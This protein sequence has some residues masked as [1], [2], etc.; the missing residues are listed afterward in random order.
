MKTAMTKTLLILPVLSAGLT[1][2]TMVQDGK[3]SLEKWRERREVSRQQKQLAADAAATRDAQDGSSLPPIFLDYTAE[4]DPRNLGFA[5]NG[6]T[7]KKSP[8]TAALASAFATPPPFTPDL[9]GSV[10]EFTSS[11]ADFTAPTSAP[12]GEIF[13]DTMLADVEPPFVGPLQPSDEPVIA[14][15]VA[16]GPVAITPETVSAWAG[17]MVPLTGASLVEPFVT[18]ALTG[19]FTPA[20]ATA[21]ADSAPSS[22]WSVSVGDTVAAESHTAPTVPATSHSTEHEADWTR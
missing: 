9:P 3:L 7:M 18:A 22:G 20:E 13:P 6:G 10:G 5:G 14:P 21:V 16:S 4:S 15:L 17:T 2:C 19:S 11:P 1:S 8:D 12:E